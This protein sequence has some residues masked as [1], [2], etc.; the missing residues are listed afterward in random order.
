MHF[1]L[2]VASLV[3]FGSM[4]KA[5]K[6]VAPDA[7]VRARALA[8]AKDLPSLSYLD[9]IERVRQIYPEMTWL[10]GEVHA[11]PEGLASAGESASPSRRIFGQMHIEFDRTA[12]G[13]AF[14]AWVLGDRYD[15]FVLPQS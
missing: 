5:D 14:L 9:L 10:T 4:A 2:L 1:F 15:D 13:I 3:G 8:L 7:S 12:N 11:T 6:P